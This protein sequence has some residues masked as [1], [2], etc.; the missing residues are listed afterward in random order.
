V[1]TNDSFNKRVVLQPSLRVALFVYN[2]IRELRKESDEFVFVRGR[3]YLL[4]TSAFFSA[5]EFKQRE[6][7]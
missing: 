1:S 5:C 3:A 4:Q 2:S 6:L 7:R